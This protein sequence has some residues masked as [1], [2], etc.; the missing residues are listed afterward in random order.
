MG[1]S[2]A[3]TAFRS[4]LFVLRQMKPNQDH[5]S[6]RHPQKVLCGSSGWTCILEIEGGL[7]CKV[8]STVLNNTL[9]ATLQPPRNRRW[10]RGGL[11]ALLGS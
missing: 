11:S 10:H 6:G 2:A 7:T 9:S 5:V 8:P 1:C 4:G 3:P